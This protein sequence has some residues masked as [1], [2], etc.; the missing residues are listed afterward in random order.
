[1]S[2][3]KK[4]FLSECNL[5]NYIFSKNVELIDKD[6]NEFY[7]IRNENNYEPR[8][9]YIYTSYRLYAMFVLISLKTNN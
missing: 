5:F 6:N 1:M 4:L 9:F 3:C 7:H 8:F 2:V